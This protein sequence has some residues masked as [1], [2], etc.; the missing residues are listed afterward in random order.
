MT[1]LVSRWQCFVGILHSLLGS[2]PKATRNTRNIDTN[3]DFVWTTFRENPKTKNDWNGFQT[4]K[5]SMAVKRKKKKLK[6]ETNDHKSHKVRNFWFPNI[7][8]SLWSVKWERLDFKSNKSIHTSVVRVCLDVVCFCKM[9]E[10]I[11]EQGSTQTVHHKYRKQPVFAALWLV[12][13]TSYIDFL[14]LGKTIKLNRTL[15]QN[16]QAQINLLIA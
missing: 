2:H 10:V 9:E 7:R 14:W 13:W 6:G 3:S 4:M 11:V 8:R 12:L 16:P 15:T 5:S 1:L